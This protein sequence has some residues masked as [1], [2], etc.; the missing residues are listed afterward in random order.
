MSAKKRPPAK[1]RKPVTHPASEPRVDLTDNPST[2]SIASVLLGS[3]PALRRLVIYW[4]STCSVYVLAVLLIFLLVEAG[5][6][7]PPVGHA[8]TIVIIIGVCCFY[9]LVRFSIRLRLRP[10]FLTLVQG[11]FATI[12]LVAAYAI[13]GEFRGATITVM[14]VMMSFCGFA[15]SV[16]QSLFLSLFLVLNLGATILWLRH[17]DPAGHP[18]LLELAHFVLAAG[19]LL[20][21]NFLTAQW[22]G[23]RRRL[24]RQKLELGQALQKIQLL[25]TNDELTRLPNRRHMNSVLRREERRPDRE[26]RNVCLA[27]IDI[28]HFKRINDGY[29]HAI[30]DQVLRLFAQHLKATLRA[31]DVLARW[32]GEEFLLLLP[33]TTE[34]T[35]LQV[36]QRMQTQLHTITVNKQVADL[37]ISFSGGL[38]T[39][40]PEEEI[41]DAV[42]R[43][44]L[45]MFQA[46]SGG[47]NAIRAY[48]S[49]ESEI[50]NAMFLERD[51]PDAIAKDQL[52]L[53]YQ[54]QV[55]RHG[56][57]IGCEA[58]V[59]W[60]HPTFGVLLPDN[61]IPLAEQSGLIF[62]LGRWVINHA[63]QQIKSWSNM[64]QSARLTIAV[65]VSA[66]EFRHPQF[67][68]Q[69]LEAIAQA[70]IEPQRLEL[71][72][73]ESML[74]EDLEDTI[75][76]MALLR[77]HGIRFS[78]DDF[79]TG[80][81][82][83]SYLRRLPLSQLKIDK[84]F[85]CDISTDGN[86]AAIAATIVALARSLGLTSVAEGVETSMQRN[87]LTQQGCDYCQGYLFSAPLDLA[88]FEK[89]LQCEVEVAA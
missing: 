23:L 32:G 79:G 81:S 83:L 13:S 71:E 46:K 34:E 15:L 87:F 52:V 5:Q 17:V 84:S 28:D 77:S 37:R 43:A 57:V 75:N 74:I 62:A 25:A 29:G 7:S 24:I 27:L 65:N 47:R 2:R 70:D 21:V 38:T 18:P 9:V 12:A 72:L 45:A 4:A 33:N 10:A 67:I 55:D 1:L 60:N 8:F 39:L 68:K 31:E 44:D 61:F 35:A 80:Y 16:P 48:R 22:N 78:L 63:C 19:M 89:L 76:K 36:L 30:G 49:Q 82:S 64:P 20:A 58:L 88:A 51:L 73:T 41:A 26:G 66:R 3:T 6:I 59:R 54:P 56:V 40:R 42:K 53:H 11:V 86:G 69:V 14:I 50:P 85:V